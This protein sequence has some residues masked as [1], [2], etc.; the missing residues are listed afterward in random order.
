MSKAIGFF[1][2][3]IYGRRKKAGCIWQSFKIPSIP[4]PAP[5]TFPILRQSDRLSQPLLASFSQEHTALTAYVP[6][7]RNKRSYSSG[8]LQQLML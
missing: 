7:R 4:A 2:Q 5:R 6:P 8:Y 3:K 1:C